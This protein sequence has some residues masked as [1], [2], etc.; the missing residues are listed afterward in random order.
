FSLNIDPATN[1]ITS[2][3]YS[4][5]ASGNLVSDPAGTFV[6]GFDSINRLVSAPAQSL[7]YRYL[8]HS[9]L[10]EK[11]GSSPATYEIRDSSGRLLGEASI[12]GSAP[13]VAPTHYLHEDRQGSIKLVT[14]S[15]GQLVGFHDY[16]P[17]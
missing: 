2:S 5:D 13:A 4:Y 15:S 9:R 8:E 11:N 3:G 16:Y 10:V 12:T 6:L 14:D 17:F 1:R 7:T